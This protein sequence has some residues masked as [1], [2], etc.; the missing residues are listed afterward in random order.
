[1]LISEYLDNLKSG[2]MMKRFFC[3]SLIIIFSQSAFSW[4]ASHKRLAKELENV[5]PY[6]KEK[7]NLTQRQALNE[8]YCLAPD[9]QEAIPSN[10]VGLE[11]MEYLRSVRI[12]S[13]IQLGD[14]KSLPHMHYLLYEALKNRKYDAA[15]YW[16]AC[17]SHAVN[18]AAS[19]HYIPS[20][21]F[22]NTMAKHFGTVSPDGKKIL[23]AETCGL[24]VDRHFN[25]PEGLAVLKKFRDSYKVTPLGEKPGDV[26]ESL[27]SM[28][29]GLR[30]ASFKHGSYLLDNIER[31]IYTDKPLPHNGVLAVSKLGVLG[32][33]AT[34][35]VLNSAWNLAKDKKKFKAEDILDDIIESKLET[36]LKQRTL[37]EMPLFKDVYSEGNA[38][39]VGVLAEPFYTDT[40]SALGN[41]SRFIA[42]NIMGSLKENK[43]SY[44]SL[45]LVTALTKGLPAAKEMPI[46][47]IPAAELSS[48]YRWIKKRDIIKIFQNYTADGGRV[49]WIASDRAT[50]LGDLSFNLKTERNSSIYT[51]KELMEEGFV[52][53]NSKLTDKG[54]DSKIKDIKTKKFPVKHIPGDGFKWTE[55]KTVLEAVDNEKLESLV[56]FKDTNDSIKTLGA[57]LKREGDAEKAEHIAISSLFFFPN[58][59]SPIVKSLNK[60]QLD[61]VSESILINAINLLK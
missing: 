16:T 26:S 47:I 57:L 29:V 58:L 2:R 43:I 27:G 44:R 51:D 39:L 46:L 54:T 33:A 28:M 48:G 30:N 21:Y 9:Y 25:L 23:E 36:L 41:T 34:A 38:G 59:H 24:Y 4:T 56:F 55:L 1:M 22:Y 40:Q 61:E 5:V 20:I 37:I 3:F 18:D 19:P 13:T 31:S 15:A 12:I 60:P 7:L 8:T 6:I 17:I 11:A 42:A 32:I 52:H 53:Y 35:D 50:F 49:L 10:I 45:N 14:I